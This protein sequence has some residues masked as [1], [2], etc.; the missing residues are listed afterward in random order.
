MCFILLVTQV[1]LELQHLVS[2]CKTLERFELF[3]LALQKHA[4]RAQHLAYWAILWYSIYSLRLY[5][6]VLHKVSADLINSE[7]QASNR[8]K[9]CD[10][11]VSV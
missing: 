8:S 2:N 6:E 1:H 11:C 9:F 5:K 4:N 10:M 3:L 7:S